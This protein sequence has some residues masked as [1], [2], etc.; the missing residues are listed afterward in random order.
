MMKNVGND[1]WQQNLT[2]LIIDMSEKMSKD[3]SERI[4]Q[5]MSETISKGK[6]K[7]CQEILDMSERMS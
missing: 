4:S 5:D 3:T 1:R 7:K 6:S 2:N